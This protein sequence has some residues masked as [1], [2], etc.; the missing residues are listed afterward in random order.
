MKIRVRL[1]WNTSQD[2]AVDVSTAAAGPVQDRAAPSTPIPAGSGQP[3]D[4]GERRRRSSP[5]FPVWLVT[6]LIAALTAVGGGSLIW[7]GETSDPAPVTTRHPTTTDPPTAPASVRDE[8]STTD[9]SDGQSVQASSTPAL[10]EFA[11]SVA[12]S[13]TASAE[14]AATHTLMSANADEQ[15]AIRHEL[16][17][18]QAQLEQTV[19][20][21]SDARLPARVASA[22]GPAKLEPKTSGRR[23]ASKKRRAR[24]RPEPANQSRTP[25]PASFWSARQGEV[26]LAN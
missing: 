11:R 21:G 10:T 12:S 22:R 24:S 1:Y 4:Q 16:A 9:A 15:D 3:A 5:Y 13:D 26:F 14:S 17:Q 20:P 2:P 23:K 7:S 6:A 25:P 18:C 19:R 8:P